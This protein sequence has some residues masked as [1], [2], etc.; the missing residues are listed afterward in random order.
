MQ[1]YPRLG[2]KAKWGEGRGG[3]GRVVDLSPKIEKQIYEKYYT[4]G[5]SIEKRSGMRGTLI[6]VIDNSS[7]GN[8][9]HIHICIQRHNIVKEL[10][11]QTM[12]HELFV[13]IKTTSAL[14]NNY[15]QVLKMTDCGPNELEQS[16]ITVLLF[17]PLIM[18]RGVIASK[19]SMTKVP[20]WR[21]TEIVSFYGDFLARWFRFFSA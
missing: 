19:W 2:Q 12:K 17:C 20:A 13:C 3:G 7:D 14:L 9:Q 21:V 4:T 1:C 10:C 16:T 8:V 5:L 6:Q 18:Q 11:M 15:S